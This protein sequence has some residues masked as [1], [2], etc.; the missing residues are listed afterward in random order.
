MSQSPRQIFQIEYIFLLQSAVKFARAP[1]ID[2]SG[3]RF[4]QA[5]LH[6]VACIISKASVRRSFDSNERQIKEFFVSNGC[7]VHDG[8]V[9][10]LIPW[11]VDMSNTSLLRRVL[12]HVLA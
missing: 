8:C 2:P 12:Q 3:V 9:I 5:F 4:E 7:M 11:M 6:A 1:S 10:F